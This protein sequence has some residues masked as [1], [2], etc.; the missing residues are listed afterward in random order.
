MPLG[1]M[2][3]L[4]VTLI[5]LVLSFLFKVAVKLRLTLPL[6]YFLLVS[7]I[8]NKWAASH[9]SLAFAILYILI[10]VSV[11]SWLF[12]L[13]DKLQERR[14]YRAIE[15]D[16]AWQIKRAKERGIPSDS[17]YFDS[18]GNLRYNDTKEIVE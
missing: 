7:S 1:L 10:A 5:L 16:M 2:L 4:S 3:S 9:E 17:V 18:D 13:K 12:A 8:L 15:E 11:I 6:I 14:Y